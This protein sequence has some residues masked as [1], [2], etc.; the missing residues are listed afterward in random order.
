MQ[1]RSNRGSGKPVWVKAHQARVGDWD[2]I[3][4][5]ALGPAVTCAALTGRRHDC[6]RPICTNI[7][8]DLAKWE[9]SRHDPQQKLVTLCVKLIKISAKLVL[10]AC[11]IIFQL[12]EV[13][14]P[15]RLWEE[16]LTAIA[17]LRPVEQPP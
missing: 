17:G 1:N 15:S 14:V 11:S 13:A 4:R 9:P 6:T 8:N 12:A 16:M 10:H 7:K 5:I 3:R 2:P